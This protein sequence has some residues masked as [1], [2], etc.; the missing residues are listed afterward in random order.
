[1]FATA[2]YQMFVK[3]L[4]LDD[5]SNEIVKVALSFPINKFH[6]KI[7]KGISIHILWWM[8]QMKESVLGFEK[9]TQPWFTYFQIVGKY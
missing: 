4:K 2:C 8:L 7:F 1:M 6:K 9:T 5:Q 3:Y